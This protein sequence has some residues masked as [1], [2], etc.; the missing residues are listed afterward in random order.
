MRRAVVDFRTFRNSDPP[1]LASVWNSQPPLETRLPRVHARLLDE[2]VLA[3]LY[4]DPDGLWLAEDS[5]RVVGFAHAGFGPAADGERLATNIGCV[6]ALVVEPRADAEPI[7]AE[8][9]RRAEE[10]LAAR[11]ASEVYAGGPG[12]VDPFYGGLYGGCRCEGLPA[13]DTVTVA[14]FRAAGYAAWEQRTVFRRDLAD[15]R[16]PCDRLY[17]QW[18]RQV[19]SDR[20]LE[21]HAGLA[22]ESWW[23]ACTLGQQR[24]CRFRFAVRSPVPR[25]AELVCWDMQPLADATGR[26]LSGLLHW[27]CDAHGWTDGMFRFLLG[28][29]LRQLAEDGV[30][31]FEAHTGPADQP[32]RQLLEK[33]DFRPVTEKI[34]LVKGL[35]SRQ[36]SGAR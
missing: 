17:S 4:F 1:R 8:L 30:E 33:L 9:V 29:T 24:R 6:S 11:G 13:E 5:Q 20:P 26:R 15:Y 12:P 3:R 27:Q 7:A 21:C 31:W 18:Q 28:E 25:V 35:E 16:P 14:R 19:T 23:D 22:A 34:V 2:T 36:A 10:Y 32:L